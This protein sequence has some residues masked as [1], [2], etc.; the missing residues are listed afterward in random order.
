MVANYFK[1]LSA[2]LKSLS[3]YINTVRLPIVGKYMIIQ[4]VSVF[5]SCRGRPNFCYNLGWFF[6]LL[7]DKRCGLTAL[8]FGY[9]CRIQKC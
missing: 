2:L 1:S 8:A 3:L 6:S 9:V 7:L 4:V 5:H